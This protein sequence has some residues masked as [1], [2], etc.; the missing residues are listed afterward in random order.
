MPNRSTFAPGRNTWKK[1]TLAILILLPTLLTHRGVSAD[2]TVHVM[3]AATARSAADCCGRVD[4]AEIQ[5]VDIKRVGD[6]VFKPIDDRFRCTDGRCLIEGLPPDTVQV[7]VWVESRSLN[8]FGKDGVRKTFGQADL[9]RSFGDI[10]VGR[11]RDEPNETRRIELHSSTTVSNFCA[12]SCCPP[13]CCQPICCPPVF[14]E[15]R[16]YSPIIERPALHCAEKPQT[17]DDVS[18]ATSTNNGDFRSTLREVGLPFRRLAHEVCEAESSRQHKN[19]LIGVD[20]LAMGR[21]RL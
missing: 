20:S 6:T 2:F 3:K 9:K 7:R 10:I 21:V 17:P 11:V 8:R 19:S 18:V 12:P 5:A 13:V 1:T 16:C 4:D 15:Q 14:R